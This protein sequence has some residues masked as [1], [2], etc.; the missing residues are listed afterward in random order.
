MINCEIIQDL[1]PLYADDLISPS[2]KALVEQHTQDCPQCRSLLRSMVAPVEPEPAK[3]E[4]AYLKAIARQKKRQTRRTVLLCMLPV[5]VVILGWW[6]YMEIHFNGMTPYTVTTD[7]AVIFAEVPELQVTDG[8]LSVTDTVFDHPAL[9]DALEDGAVEEIPLE[10]TADLLAVITPKGATATSVAVLSGQSIC[11]DFSME[12]LRIILEYIDA[13][14]SGT[15]DLI[16][17]TIGVTDQHGEPGTVYTMDYA[18]GLNRYWC[19]KT[20]M[21]HIW[22]G[23]LTMP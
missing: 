21:R 16:R 18:V 17:K 3:D 5:L 23:F 4:S 2:G 20:R 19:E 11:M 13:D 15:V 8:E 6:I 1:M 7:E 9:R 12:E 10:Q 14:G 22:F